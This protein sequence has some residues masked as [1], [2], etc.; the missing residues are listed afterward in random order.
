M[1][2][3]YIIIGQAIVLLIESRLGYPIHRELAKAHLA[4][5]ETES[6]QK[7]PDLAI[8]TREVRVQMDEDDTFI[9][10]LLPFIEHAL[11][12]L[13]KE[14]NAEAKSKAKAKRK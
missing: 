10:I 4:E 7:Y 8:S 1:T 3:V 12:L 6:L 2:F 9:P 11:E 5:A 13:A 14:R